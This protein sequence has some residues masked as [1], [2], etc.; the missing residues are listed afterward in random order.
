[1][2]R[3]G[4]IADTHGLVRPEALEALQGCEALIHAGDIGAAG[5]IDRLAELAVV[6][7]IRGNVDTGEWAAAFP[8]TRLVQLAGATIYVIHDAK[9]LARWPAPPDARVIVCGHS[10][11]ARIDERGGVLLF[12]PGSAGPRRFRLPVSVGILHLDGDD[13]PRPELVTLDV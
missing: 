13:R 3:I 1:L 9:A 10:H 7:A 11:A 12:N 6:H 8:E 2:P 5:V 4:V